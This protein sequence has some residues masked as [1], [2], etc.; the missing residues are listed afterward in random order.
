M[1]SCNSRPDISIKVSWKEGPCFYLKTILLWSSPFFEKEKKRLLS[2]FREKVF[3]RQDTEVAKKKRKSE[4]PLRKHSKVTIR[5]D[6]KRRDQRLFSFKK[7][8]RLKMY[9]WNVEI[10]LSSNFIA[11]HR[12]LELGLAPYKQWIISGDTVHSFLLW[13]C[14]SH[15]QARIYQVRLLRWNTS[16]RHY[17]ERAF[18]TKA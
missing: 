8:I 16:S 15:L 12:S 11:C 3:T 4:I 7:V 18:E 14:D 2:V 1:K 9:Y 6:C 5:S 17:F 13:I 10:P